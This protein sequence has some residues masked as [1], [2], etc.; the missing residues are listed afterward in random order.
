MPPP[1][2]PNPLLRLALDRTIPFDAI[3]AEHIE[4]AITELIVQARAALDELV[5]AAGPRTFA[6]TLGKLE[7]ATERLDLVMGVVDHL[8]GVAT[9]PELR[10]AF[11][12][13]QPKVSA[14]QSQI[15][16]SPG[17]WGAI[18][19]F[20]ETDEA[21]QLAGERRRLLDKTVSEFKR[22]GALLDPAG[23]AR[24]S[25]IEVELAQLTLRFSQNVLDATNA[26]ELVVDDAAKLAGLPDSAIAAA[27][28]SAEQKG[29]AGYRLTL[30][31]PSYIPAMTYLDDASLREALYRAS[32]TRATSG[33]LDNRPLVSAI[34]ELRSE[35]AKLLGYATFADLVCEDRMA[36]TGEAARRFVQTL[37][38][39]TRPYFEQENE[40]LLAYRRRL[41]GS[42][43]PELAPWDVS[44]YAE[45]LRR[46]RY[47]Y[48]EEALR[49]YF[50]LD[51]VL[52]GAF[53]IAERLYGVRIEPWPDA[54]VWNST[55]RAYRI[56]EADGAPCSSFYVDVF[57]REDKRDGAWM[58][59]L[60]STV[61]RERGPNDR[62]IAVLAAN[63]TPPSGDRPALLSHREVETLFHEFG[64][65]M[66]HASSQ[67]G[68]RTLAGTNVA[69]DFVELPSQLMEN[70]CWERQALALF[71]RHVDTNEPIPGAMFERMSAA[72]TYRAANAMMRQLGFAELDL[73]LHMDW[74]AS[75]GGDIIE[76]ARQI[77]ADHSPAPLP[78]DYAMVC[79]FSH[80]FASSVGYAAGYYSYK[81]AEVLDADA[82]SRFKEEGIF[83]RDAGLAFRTHVLARG[84]A[85]EPME[86]YRRFMGREPTL[87][88]LLERSGLL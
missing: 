47:D 31:A 66:H 28:A 57:P 10:A 23:K 49:P 58:H 56:D 7:A 72:R 51:H 87:D 19:A 67:V 82:F 71:A 2:S 5:E 79:G 44:Y 42:S 53:S 80:L 22:S 4:P 77:L 27:R 68:L 65:L 37:R 39:R 3:K 43:A 74:D 33:A 62:H 85:E 84:D 60:I 12:A 55:V 9:T 26:F 25:A 54:P 16:M 6:N 14:F 75:Q 24:L 76:Y 8:E 86:L 45:K 30:Q 88:A 69:R 13:V 40:A 1:S 29:L 34:V 41:E 15:P 20:A 70:W 46:E 21:A 73:A 32:S 50:P 17:I 18:G 64:H 81:W 35:K 11:N 38:D 83:S 59:G 52:A 36:K 78:A 63:F 61:Q 48:D